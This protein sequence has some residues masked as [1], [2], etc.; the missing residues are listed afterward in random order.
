MMMVKLLCQLG[1]VKAV[2][3]P[4]LDDRLITCEGESGHFVR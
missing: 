1:R 4:Q 2:P 3:E